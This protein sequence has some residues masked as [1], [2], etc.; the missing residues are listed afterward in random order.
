MTLALVHPSSPCDC[1][2]VLCRSETAKIPL[3]PDWPCRILIFYSYILH[4]QLLPQNRQDP[5]WEIRKT[6]NWPESSGFPNLDPRSALTEVTV[7]VDGVLERA[8]SA[9]LRR[10]GD[11]AAQ[12]VFQRHP[13]LCGSMGVMSLRVFSP[14]PRRDLIPLSDF[15]ILDLLTFSIPHSRR[16]FI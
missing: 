2:G 14:P 5:N 8:P 12:D 10:L 11:G 15:S 16:N 6:K 1:A 3:I 13:K 9:K 4:I 7:V